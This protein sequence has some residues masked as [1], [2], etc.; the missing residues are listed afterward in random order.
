MNIIKRTLIILVVIVFT[1]TSCKKETPDYE[2]KNNT[3]DQAWLNVQKA[4]NGIQELT[5]FP[6]VNERKDVF[7]VNYGGVGYPA[8]DINVSFAFD[9]KSLDSLNKIRINAGDDPLLPFPEGSYNLDRTSTIIK[10][11]STSSDYITLTYDPSKFDLAKEYMLPLKATNSQGY[12]FRERQSTILYSAAVVEKQHSKAGWA[13]TVSSIHTGESTG[14]PAALIDGNISTFWHTPYDAN[15]PKFPHWAEVDFSKEIYVT[16][17]GLT[18]RQ[19]N[20]NGFKT[21]DVE[22][23]KDGSTWTTLVKDGVMEQTE[24]EMQKFPIEPQYLKKIKIIMKDNFGGQVY[25]H[26]AEIDALGY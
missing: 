11:G 10:S 17:I 18:R 7:N 25:T 13:A 20:I 2:K 26:L 22:G 12:T 19:N 23:T 9:Q 24:L 8:E 6:V 1:F 5:L 16:Q 14:T 3:R 15:A 4:T 21:F